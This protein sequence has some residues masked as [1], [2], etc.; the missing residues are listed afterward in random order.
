MSLFSQVGPEAREAGKT[1]YFAFQ[2]ENTEYNTHVLISPL[3]NYNQMKSKSRQM[4]KYSCQ[5][6]WLPP[7]VCKPVPVFA[8]WTFSSRATAIQSTPPVPSTCMLWTPGERSFGVSGEK[9][10]TVMKSD[11]P[12]HYQLW[13]S[14]SVYKAD[15]KI[16]LDNWD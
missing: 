13:P 7:L 9:L 5:D 2:K 6:S 1:K 12:S 15:C 4:L 11:T 3:W 14:R 10:L 8:G 16:P